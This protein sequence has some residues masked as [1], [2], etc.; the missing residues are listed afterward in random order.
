MKDRLSLILELRSKY[1]RSR[2]GLTVEEQKPIVARVFKKIQEH[3]IPEILITCEE[4]F[5]PLFN[6]KFTKQSN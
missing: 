6:E 3:G 4:A 2:I 5:F 1:Q